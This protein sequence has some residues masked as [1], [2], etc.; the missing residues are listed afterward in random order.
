[1]RSLAIQLAIGAGVLV[2]SACGVGG[3]G[4]GGTGNAAGVGGSGG[5]GGSGGQAGSAGSGGCSSPS[6]CA[7]PQN[8]CQ[9]ATCESQVC[10][11]APT[12]AGTP[13]VTQ[14]P[15]DCKRAECDGNGNSASVNDD[16]DIEDDSNECTDDVC[17][18]GT[19]AHNN[20]L[21][22]TKCTAGLCDT[23]GQCVQCL[24]PN[25]CPGTDDECKQRTC[26]GGVCGT[27]F[28]AAGT[29]V[30]AQTAGDCKK[31]QCDG[32][33]NITSVNDDSDLPDDSNPCTDD[34]CSAGT[35]ANTPKS[36]GT[37]CGASGVCNAAGKCVGCNA[38]TDCP[39]NDDECK[40]RTCTANVCGLSFT[41]ANTPLASQT[42]GDCKQA[43]C[44]GSGNIGSI[45]LDTDPIVDGKECT[46]DLCTAG[47][48]SN[49]PENQ[50]KTCTESG[51]KFCDGAG[52]CVECNSATTCGGGTCT[53]NQ[54]APTVTSTVPADG[55]NGIAI[56]TGISATFSEAMNP[57]TLSAQTASGSCSGSI[58]VSSDDF[59]SCIGMSQ[60]AAVMSGGN[61]TA[62]LT[63]AAPL[64]YGLTYKIRV[65]TTATDSAGVAMASQYTSTTGFSTPFPAACMGDIVI[66]QVYGGGGNSG[67]AFT[68]DFVELHNRTSSSV[69]L[70]GW[71]VQYAS[72]TG[73]NWSV[74]PL[75]GS[76][77]AGGYFL[78]RMAGGSTGSP[79]PTPDQIG[80]QS[81]AGTAAKVALVAST[82]ALSG[83]C[84]T[85][86]SPPLVDF[87]GYGNN[88]NCFEGSGST[89]NL[90]N[91][92]GALRDVA[93]CADADDNSTD[94]VVATPIPRNTAAAPAYC[95]CPAD[96]QNETGAATEADYCNLQSPTNLAVTSGAPSALVYGR[97]FESG[98]TEA[99]GAHSTVRAQLGYGLVGSD[100][101]TQTSWAFMDAAYNVQVGNDDEY[102]A[103]FTGPPISG[104][105]SYAYTYRMSV[106][107]GM[108]WTYCDSDGAGSNAGLT[109]SAGALGSMSV[110]P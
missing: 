81:M 26:T 3:S 107:S 60:A 103:R 75:S 109:F 56:S 40:K 58:Q 14:T 82:A 91:T 96:T 10:G 44:D 36:P 43:V 72:S 94:F 38:P 68:H 93:G 39:G 53:N 21:S 42:A 30:T 99:A 76:I 16:T 95:P 47:T 55:A 2:S 66:S 79:L 37:K 27:G 24:A 86:T 62:S 52:S 92:R 49:P 78:L 25:D 100:P 19:P 77:P 20:K 108:T 105:K 83:T 34:S 90:S 102:S 31:A 5:F 18:A 35:P 11:A 32:S 87:V 54:C 106:D 48:P 70:S 101:S 41:P 80:T 50:T 64:A 67:A 65:T 85:L 97:V 110:T 57:A 69:N 33:G 28:S 29:P 4:G 9:Q 46:Q 17:N 6:D 51:G 45:N 8:E 12:P 23:S 1:M 15:G 88:A 104:A 71:S 22:G 98:V 84:P 73:S 13:L 74:T 59:S 61:T 63:P 89:A 7:P